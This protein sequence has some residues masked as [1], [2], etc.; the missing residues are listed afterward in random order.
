MDRTRSVLVVDD[1]DTLRATLKK[2]FAKAG[3]DASTAR[4]GMEALDFIRER[5]VDIV[6]ADVRMPRKNGLSLLDSVHEL[7]PETKVVVMTAYGTADTEQD[8]L[9]R[10]AYAYVSKPVSR[11]VLLELCD[12]ACESQ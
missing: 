6:L 10:G 7:R 12:R 4:D 9:R 2:I 1:D 11:D 5:A 3:Y 8:A